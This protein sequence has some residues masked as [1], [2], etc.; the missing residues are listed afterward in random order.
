MV[1]RFVLLAVG[2]RPDVYLQA[3]GACLSVLAHVP[4]AQRQIVLFTSAPE[5]FAWLQDELRTRARA[6]EQAA[7]T[8]DGRATS[9]TYGALAETCVACHDAYLLAH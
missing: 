8:R 9:R 5:R 4:R 3:H 6:L 2:D 1:T 7:R